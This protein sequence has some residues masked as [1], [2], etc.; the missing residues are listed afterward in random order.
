[1]SRRAGE[2]ISRVPVTD[3]LRRHCLT[4]GATT[5][6]G[7][8]RAP[9]MHHSEKVRWN[10]LFARGVIQQRFK[11][12]LLATAVRAVYRSTAARSRSAGLPEVE[13]GVRG[14]PVFWKVRNALR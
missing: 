14:Q 9:E 1:V 12:E 7:R 2:K 8:F 10:R 13:A 11:I 6:V 3:Q 4:L 5:L